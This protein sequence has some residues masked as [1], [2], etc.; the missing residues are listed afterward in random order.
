MESSNLA[1]DFKGNRAVTAKLQVSEHT[2]DGDFRFEKFTFICKL[3]LQW[4]ASKL[5]RR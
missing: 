5:Q 4:Y 1:A 3:V 2:E